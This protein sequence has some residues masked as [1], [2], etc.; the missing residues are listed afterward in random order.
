M[1]ARSLALSAAFVSASLVVAAPVPKSPEQLGPT[2]KDELRTGKRRMQAL[3]LAAITYADDHNGQWPANV[4]DEKGNALLSWRVRL[5]PYLGQKEL[6]EK[7]DLTQA[8]DG[9]ANRKLVEQ[10]P[11]CF[12]P[13]RNVT[14]EQG[15]T[16]FQGFD[17]LGAA[18][19]AGKQLRFPASFPDGTSNTIALV[20]AGEAVTWTKPADIP[21]DVKGEQPKLGGVYDGEFWVGMCDGSAYL[22][23]T[24]HIDFEQFQRAVTTADG[25]IVNLDAAFGWEQKRK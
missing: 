9:K 18:F 10:M 11:D 12:A 8:W 14:K 19:E 24:K 7:F 5:L 15:V 2:T 6:Y 16:F 20:E 1:T 21:F 25:Y 3:V 17:G 22:A 4:T 13:A 23:V